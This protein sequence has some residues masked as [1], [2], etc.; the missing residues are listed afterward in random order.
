[1]RLSSFVQVWFGWVGLS[2]PQP[3][4]AGAASE[5]GSFRHFAHAAGAAHP[6]RC[7]RHRPKIG[8]VPSFRPLRPTLPSESSSF[9]HFTRRGNAASQSATSENSSK[10]LKLNAEETLTPHPR[11][12]GTVM[13]DSSPHPARCRRHRPQIGFVPSFRLCTHRPPNWVRFVAPAPPN[14]PGPLC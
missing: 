14:H 1:M 4:G 7:D 12:A 6:V 5:S 9:R 8:F 13:P 3:P 10:P 2:S 11:V